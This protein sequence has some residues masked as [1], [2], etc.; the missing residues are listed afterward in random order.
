MLFIITMIAYLTASSAVAS[1]VYPCEGILNVYR[2]ASIDTDVREGKCIIIENGMESRAWDQAI[3]G[4]LL[5]GKSFYLGRL[6]NVW[7]TVYDRKPGRACHAISRVEFHFGTLYYACQY[8][9]RE[10]VVL[11]YDDNTAFAESTR[12]EKVRIGVSRKIDSQVILDF[13]VEYCLEDFSIVM[14]HQQEMLR[15][16]NTKDRVATSHCPRHPVIGI[17][18]V[19]QSTLQR[20]NKR[21]DVHPNCEETH[22][23][24]TMRWPTDWRCVTDLFAVQRR[25]YRHSGLD[26]DGSF[27]TKSYAA[28]AGQVVFSGWGNGHGKY[29]VI[30]HGNNVRTLYAHHYRNMVSVGDWVEAGGIVGHTGNSGKTMGLVG[31]HLHFEV[32]VNGQHRDPLD[33]ID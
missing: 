3:V 18:L 28:A 9:G 26:I 12:Y 30:D 15:P 11:G 2:I 27:Q 25:G 32:Q 5:D 4:P 7:R 22:G 8:D 19:K 1:D 21:F 14:N 20:L 10:F 17:P 31:T 6:G 13:R 29:V 16:F 24:G 23:R 33:Y